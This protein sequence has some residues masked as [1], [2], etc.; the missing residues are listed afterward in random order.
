MSYVINT[1]AQLKPILVGFRKSKGMSQKDMAEK[2][3]VSQQAYQA[4]E[5]N[6]QSVTVER[7]MKV[8]NILSVK[9]HL[10]DTELHLPFEKAVIRKLESGPDFMVKKLDDSFV[11]N[12]VK[13]K[14]APS[15]KITKKLSK[16]SW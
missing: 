1:P 10:S 11:V 3:N 9:L 16:D 5:S 15:R 6:P 4:L 14:N 2:L 7:L 13:T 12:K 8:L